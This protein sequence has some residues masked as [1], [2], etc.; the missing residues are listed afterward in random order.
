MHDFLVSHFGYHARKQVKLDMEVLVGLFSKRNLYFR[1]PKVASATIARAVSNDTMVLPHCYRPH[2]INTLLKLSSSSFKFTFVR[3]P[4]T[5]FSSAFK[6]IAKRA[7]GA[8]LNPF[9]TRQREIIRQAGDINRFCSLL[10]ELLADKN[11]FLIHFYPQ[12]DY[13]FSDGRRLVDYV[14]KYE[15]FNESCR[16]MHERYGYKLDLSFGPNNKNRG[17]LALDHP[18]DSLLDLG[19]TESSLEILRAIYARDLETFKYNG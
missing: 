18:V 15:H 19:V 17:K 7:E 9:D 16:S 6:W 5:R 8:P 2:R 1:M 4:F 14:G 3:H 13:I 10:P 11:A 12:S